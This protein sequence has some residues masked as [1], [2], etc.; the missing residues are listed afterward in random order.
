M[1]AVLR[2]D[3]E[4]RD[5]LVKQGKCRSTVE[6]TQPLLVVRSGPARPFV[7]HCVAEI[8]S[9][10][11]R[12]HRVRRLHCFSALP[13]IRSAT[14]GEKRHPGAI[15]GY[16]HHSVD[17]VDYPYAGPHRRVANMAPHK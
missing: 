1:A 14:N 17:S 4:R 9:S 16:W 5:Y 12:S 15:H 13:S 6:G 3:V 10:A 11:H 7:Q 2:L 8:S